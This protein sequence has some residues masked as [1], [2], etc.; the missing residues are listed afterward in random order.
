MEFPSLLQRRHRR[1]RKRLA[2][3]PALSAAPAFSPLPTRSFAIALSAASLAVALSPARAADPVEHSLPSVTVSAGRGITLDDLDVSTTVLERDEI[4]ASPQ[5]ST[6]QLMGR[7]PGVFTLHQPA[8]QL[9]PTA[10]VFSIRGFGTTT[11][12]NTLVTIDG[13]PAND[14][15]FRTVD[16]TRIPKESIERIEVIRGG[17]ATSLWGNLALG[18]VVNIVTRDP[19]PDEGRIGASAGSHGNRS[20]SAAATLVAGERMRIGIDADAASSDGY[21]SVPARFR[22]PRMRT[23]ASRVDN[24]RF[25]GV[26]TPSDASRYYV[27]GSLHRSRERGLVWD[28]A[29]NEWENRR[30]VA[31]GSTRLDAGGSLNLSGWFDDS[32]MDTTNAGQ[33]PA[34]DLFAPAAAVPFVSQIEQVRYRSVGGSAFY[35]HDLGALADLRLGVDLRAVDADDDIRLFGPSAPNAA[36]VVRGKHS[37]QGLFAQGTWRPATL[38][39]DVTLGLRQDFWQASGASVDGQIFSSGATL[40]Q[41][42]PDASHSRFNP[43]IGARYF[44]L[45]ELVLRAAAYRNFAAPGMNQMYRSFVSGSSYTATNPDLAPQTNR[46]REIGVDYTTA[47]GGLA[48]TLFDNDLRD[49]IDFV[50]LCTTAAACDPLIA[51]TGLASGSVTRVNRYVN[52]GDA[53]LRGFELLGHYAPNRA[54]R[55]EGGFVRTQAHLKRSAYTEPAATPPAPVHRQLGQVPRW[56]LTLG[57]TWQATPALAFAAQLASF[58]S[59]WNNTAHTQSNDGATLMDVAV[60]YRLN[61]AIEVWGSVQ[62]LADR[63]YYAQGLTYT[64]IEGATPSRSAMPALGIPRTVHVGM[65]ASF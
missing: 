2:P 39:L 40:S 16:W 45:P 54:V 20:L 7:I 56:K 41:R 23:T 1:C 11:N 33:S 3:R 27:K 61:R 30:I 36:I 4:L 49:F 15:F 10:Q 18:G 59:F 14:A 9:H 57:A 65:R 5:T 48:F 37:F 47:T 46:G 51:G 21:W 12:V 13:V 34:F 58:P 17:G 64:T 44:V 52:A 60:T 63:R 8:G 29:R 50:P 53:V 31:G 38:P 35:Q 43:R 28:V 19:L 26:F 6:E 62:N 55:F 25:T 22:N 32:G 24:L 42:L